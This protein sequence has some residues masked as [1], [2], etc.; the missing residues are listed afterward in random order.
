MTDR[1]LNPATSDDRTLGAAPGPQFG[2]G[3]VKPQ[4]A[5]GDT[6]GN[7]G[8]DRTIRSNTQPATAADTADH[9]IL[10]QVEYKK[11]ECL[12]GRSGEAQVFL[13]SRDDKE[14]VL[15]IYYP[16]YEVN[17]KLLQVIRSIDFE[18]IVNLIDYGKTYIDGKRRYYE[19]MEYLRGKTLQDY[20]L[21]GDINQFRR[22][23]LQ[24]AAALAYCHNNNILHK[25]IKPSNFFFRDTAHT[26]LVLGDF[27]ISALLEQDGKP[28]R[29]TQARTPIYA[30][31]EMYSDVIDGIVE[32]TPAADYYS[33]GITLFALWIG[34]NPLSSNERLMMRQ[35]SE[36]RLPR[37]NELPDQVRTIVQGLTTVNPAS[38]WGIDEVERWF[39]GEN[40]KVDLSSPY[41]QYKSFIVDPERN[42]VADNV[43]ELVPMLVENERLAMGYLYSGRIVQWLESC[44]NI[45]LATAVKDI[46]VNRYPADQKAGLMAAVYTM[47]PTFQ[48][49]DVRGDLCDDIHSVS[50][51]LLS[52]QAEYAVLL[53]NPHD[54][55]FLYLE[56]RTKC[57][58]ERLRGYF[59]QP[60]F[61]PHVAIMRMAYEIDNEIPFLARNSSNTVEQ[62]VKSFGNENL[63][64][65]EWQSLCDG[66]LLSWMYSHEDMMACESLRI[67]TKDQEYSQTLAYKVLYN[68]DRKA[69][70]DLRSAN[71]P[72]KVGWLLNER[73]AQAEHLSDEEF[74]EAMDDFLGKNSRFAYYAQ[75]HGWYEQ[76]AEANRCFDMSST[77][78]RERVS[79]Y[80]NKTALYRFCRILGITPAYHLSDGTKLT[81]GLK[82][83]KLNQSVVRD[84]I[85]NGSF[86]QWLSIFY[87]EDSTRDFTEE[88]SYEHAVVDWLMELGKYDPTFKYY[89]R[90]VDAR[91]ETEARMTSVRNSYERALAKERIWR[92]LFYGLCG[93]WMLLV[94]VFGVTGRDYLLEHSFLSIGLPV[95]GMSTIIVA[96][97]AYFKGYG[98]LLSVLWGLLGALSAF[99]PVWVLDYMNAHVPALFNVSI[100]VMTL[101]Y[102]WVCH[103]TDFRG[104]SQTDTKFVNEVLDDD[105]QS[106]LLEPLYFTFK[107]KSFRYNASKFGALDDLSE[108]VGSIS[109]E[110][111][112]HYLM[113][114]LF[115]SI[116]I[117]EFVVF[118]PKLLDIRKPYL[119]GS[120]AVQ[121]HQ[122][123][124]P[125]ENDVE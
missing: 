57:D 81:D 19:L 67:L 102:M 91:K 9:F 34:G 21:N 51:S 63:T 38:R 25:D 79:A 11:L 75:M 10:K 69:A 1:T 61:K 30:A 24:A 70:Y 94:L 41:L 64:E 105:I 113:W 47:E 5:A 78:N 96:T 40:V 107:T 29:T 116:L 56:T 124:T 50:I 26:E 100:V 85:K 97:R 120:P 32:V 95:G 125:I 44:G 23:A 77:E 93:L 39:Q 2:E 4:P 80:D 114:C 37:L 83:G 48:Y 52:Y 73:L 74:N 31:P 60:D 112:L 101:A 58:V 76:L 72:Q 28:Y 35:K 15:K 62:I 14:Y 13:V 22:I 106:S 110:S 71:T 8:A 46:V 27:G 36:G 89:K 90:F 86:A 68:L 123:I 82:L 121:T 45:K 7:A 20:R 103:L 17:K 65:D 53:K 87:H 59:Q 43:Q 117:I 98:F 115:V 49:E 118:S 66:R 3:T 55:L 108:Q 54:K 92:Y 42:L 84:E 6:I 18:M 119:K 111:V 12:S 88:Y 33:L 109:G 16:N 104:E 99:I 122:V